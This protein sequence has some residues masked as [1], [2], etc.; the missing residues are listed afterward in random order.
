MANQY[1]LFWDSISGDRIYNSDSFEEWLKK[2]FTTGV[3]N[4]DCQVVAS[5]GMTI[6]VMPGYANVDGKVNVIKLRN[7]L[8]INKS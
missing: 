4:G 3:F 7:S 5:S 6:T 8:Q 1:W 2:F